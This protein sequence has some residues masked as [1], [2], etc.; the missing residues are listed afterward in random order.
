MS[1]V[2][3]TVFGVKSKTGDQSE[4]SLGGGKAV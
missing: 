3:V 4:N 1:D 2:V